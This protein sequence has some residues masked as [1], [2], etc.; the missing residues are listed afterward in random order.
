MCHHSKNVACSVL[1]TVGEDKSPSDSAWLR[2]SPA[3]VVKESCG[4]SFVR[5]VLHKDQ[6][7]SVE[8]QEGPAHQLI[9]AGDGSRDKDGS[10]PE[11]VSN[12]MNAARWAVYC[13]C[14]LKQATSCLWALSFLSR[15]GKESCGTSCVDLIRYH[16]Q[17]KGHFNRV[18]K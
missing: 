10:E 18:T 9:Y 8:K 13:L 2:Q 17:R 6:V 1:C 14:D 4:N 15:N 12:W 11:V 16:W 5:A 7:E 3:C